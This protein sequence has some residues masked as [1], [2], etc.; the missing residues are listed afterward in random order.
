[1][2]SVLFSPMKLSEDCMDSGKVQSHQKP[3]AE[4]NENELKSNSQIPTALRNYKTT[5][6]PAFLMFES[7]HIRV[8]IRAE[9]SGAK[10]LHVLQ[11]MREMGRDFSLEPVT[12]SRQQGSC[13][14]THPDYVKQSIQKRE[15]CNTVFQRTN[16]R[17][18]KYRKEGATCCTTKRPSP[19]NLPQPS[20]EKSFWGD[21]H[22]SLF[23][24][25]TLDPKI[26]S[27]RT[28]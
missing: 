18:W 25:I 4:W 23:Q 24:V 7:L 12:G 2:K 3:M 10:L 6:A 22:T 5:Q 13:S 8:R 1:M 28:S 16:S 14:G 21:N 17:S 26:R 15:K 27:S 19:I 20:G 11:C 9:L